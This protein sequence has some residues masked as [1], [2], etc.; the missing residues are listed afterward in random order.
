MKLRRLTFKNLNSLAGTWSVNF[1][2]PGFSG[3]LFAITGPTGAGKTTLLDALCLALFR[4]TP[5]LGLVTASANEIMTRGTKE[6]FAEATFSVDG[7]DYTAYWSQKKTSGRGGAEKLQPPKCRFSRLAPVEAVLAEKADAMDRAVES[8]CRLDFERF[9]RTVV[10]PQGGFAAFL[11]ADPKSRARLLEELTGAGLYRAISRQVYVRAKDEKDKLERIVMA[12]A[13]RRVMSAEERAAARARVDESLGR[14][15]RLREETDE[16]RAA[17]EWYRRRDELSRQIDKLRLDRERAAEERAAFAA[18]AEALALAEKARAAEDLHRSLLRAREK[19]R[20]TRGRQAR[21]KSRL[22]AGARASDE[23][24]RALEA[25]KSALAKLDEAAER[26]SAVRARTAE[27]D[28]RLAEAE[29]E[30]ASRLENARG[31]RAARERGERAEDGALAALEAATLRLGEAAREESRSREEFEIALGAVRRA[32]LSEL[33]RQLADGQPCPLCGSLHHPAP[34]AAASAEKEL[35]SL[36]EAAE[37]SRRRSETARRDL[38]D[39]R[40][41]RVRLQAELKAARSALETSRRLCEEASAAA[42]AARDGIELLRQKRTELF[43]SRDP[44][45]ET[46]RYRIERAR[47]ESGLD[48]ARARASEAGV[49]LA[50]AQAESEQL[51]AGARSLEAETADDEAAFSLR[52]RT[53]GFR[54]EDEWLSVS[55][56]ED[57][58]AA[59]REKK[60]R[61]ES[62]ERELSVLFPRALD[63]LTALGAPPKPGREGLDRRLEE[64][65]G[66]LT[67][68]LTSRG[69]D[70]E[71][72]ARDGENRA[73]REEL[74]AQAR[75]RE[76]TY[77]VWQSLSDKIG[78]AGGDRFSSYVQ[79]LTFR[80]LAR[81]A[82]AQLA[83]LSERYRLKPADG[84]PLSL[85]VIDLWQGGAARSSKNLSGGESFIVSLALA[86]ALSHGMKG[87]KVDS[88]FLDEG[89]GSLDEESLEIVLACLDRLRESGKVIGVISHV[90]RLRERIDCRIS[91]I[92]DGG[93]HSRL[94][95]PGCSKKA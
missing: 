1:D 54:G 29:K 72:L 33:R 84:D 32:D 24:A 39:A 69:A 80:R 3:G 42:G 38:D 25:A 30:L 67:A 35:F 44:A 59:L 56:S 19:L 55:M 87:V 15:K 63:E 48:A 43:G 7:A 90:E 10:L 8:V 37:A 23:A 88:L 70:E 20:E 28:R 49:A 51:A 94:S 41:A 52:L 45:E 5:R 75:A 62:R 83:R 66:E 4:R 92:P 86:L 13:E 40:A 22:E 17:A 12:A 58:R 61:L 81:A 65:N 9:T 21:A 57:E 53:L 71:A 60:E 74:E 47:A 34:F 79:G 85:D 36:R 18:D 27:L 2:D 76:K 93:G 50:R 31:L 6:C 46:E 82:N 91:V 89:F 26:E 73:R 68:I 78:S 16:L 77:A 64:L 11:R 14:E 95:G